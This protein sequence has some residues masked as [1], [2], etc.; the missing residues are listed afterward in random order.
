MND[1]PLGFR[2]SLT[3]SDAAMKFYTSLSD[4]EKSS[5]INYLQN[6]S[7]GEEAIEKINTAINS[8]ENKNLSF[9]DM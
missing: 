4:K 7:S 6:C 8:L 9:I 3:N 5:V 2:F 1:L